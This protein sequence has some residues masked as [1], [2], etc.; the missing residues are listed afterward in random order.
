MRFI[1][2]KSFLVVAALL[3]FLI[4]LAGSLLW[5][6]AQ[7]AKGQLIE[8]MLSNP[9]ANA[10]VAYTFDQNGMLIE[11]SS[12]IFYNPDQPL[13]LASTVKLIVLAAY[14]DAVIAGDLDPATLV[15]ISHWE[16][17][18][19]PNTD[20]NA[21]RLGLQSLGLKADEYGFALDQT[22]TVT[23]EDLA[24]IMIHYSGNAATDYL[25]SLIGQERI[26]QVFDAAGVE[27]HS[28]IC[29]LLGPGLLWMNHD[30][31]MQTLEEFKALE[32]EYTNQDACPEYPQLAKYLE[33]DE[34]REAQIKLLTGAHAPTADELELNWAILQFSAELLPKG[35]AR[36]YAH[37]LALIGSGNFI[38]PDIS[39]L[40]QGYIETLPDDWPLRTFFFQRHGEKS[41]VTAGVLSQ[42][43]YAV[44][45]FGQLAGQHRV[46]VIIAN[47]LPY[48]VWKSAVIYESLYLFQLDIATG[49]DIYV[50]AFIQE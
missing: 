10:V 29:S 8:N 6:N 24:R 3:L 46:V 32:N 47:Q 42:A 43:S 25:L 22:A 15:P 35:T 13:V 9:E 26:K 36:E 28:P 7:Q 39:E 5:G 19:L 23:L 33:N 20:G 40:M 50:N 17:Y 4:L 18:Y 27:S 12:N 14:A 44:P 16:A 2:Q 41:G 45:K 34:W 1:K 21:H 48:Q 37:L 38:S 30:S 31:P 11:D 49:K